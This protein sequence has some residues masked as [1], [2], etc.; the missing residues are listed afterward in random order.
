[1]NKLTQFLIGASLLTLVLNF[2]KVMCGIRGHDDFME[3]EP[4][5][6]YLFCPSCG[7]RSKGW[8]IGKPKIDETLLEVCSHKVIMGSP[9]LDLN[10]PEGEAK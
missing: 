9:D 8:E 1:M 3:F 7:H 4:N 10:Q 5:R 2:K 6:L